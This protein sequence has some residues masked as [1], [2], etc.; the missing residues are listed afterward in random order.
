MNATQIIEQQIL[1]Q[2]G[3]TEKKQILAKI[4]EQQKQLREFAQAN[5]ID[6]VIVNMGA[7]MDVDE[8][9]QIMYPSYDSEDESDE[10]E[11][12]DEDDEDDEQM[13]CDCCICFDDDG[14]YV[15]RSC[16]CKGIGLRPY[17]DEEK[18]DLDKEIQCPNCDS[19]I[20]VGQLIKEDENYCEN[21]WMIYEDEEEETWEC[22]E[23]G[24]EMVEN[25]ISRHLVSGGCFCKD[26][27]KFPEDK[28]VVQCDEC[29]YYA[30]EYVVKCADFTRYNE[31]R[32]YYCLDC[33]KKK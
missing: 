15:G 18:E 23:C 21:C 20:V 14:V 30:T 12:D 2:I 7:S 31:I 28:E 1:V 27:D 13:V 24:K 22:Y 9:F 33:D 4:A 6:E 16:G 19:F 29:S 8:M 11:D 10:D 32:H 26:C 17:K 25:E 5:G 3:A